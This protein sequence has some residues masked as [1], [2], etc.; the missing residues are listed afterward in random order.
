MN[1]AIS[2]M[3]WA[4]WRVKID[5]AGKGRRRGLRH[6][7]RNRGRLWHPGIYAFQ[8]RVAG[9]FNAPSPLQAITESLG[10]VPVGWCLPLD[11]LLIFLR[12][13]GKIGWREFAVSPFQRKVV[14]FTEG[15]CHLYG[16]RLSPFQ[17]KVVTYAHLQPFPI[18][19][20]TC[21]RICW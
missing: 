7:H 8:M 18:L 21:V 9:Y 20:K 19:S 10:S 13:P 15:G 2:A 1:A 4:W 6:C 16:G 17:S 5:R 14:T 11:A 3:A 12:H